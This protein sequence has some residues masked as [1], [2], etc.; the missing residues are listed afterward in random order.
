MNSDDYCCY[1]KTP[2]TQ[3]PHISKLVRD[4]LQGK[5]SKDLYGAEPSLENLIQQAKLKA[6]KFSYRRPLH[7]ALRKQYESCSF[8]LSPYDK[9]QENVDALLDDQT[10]CV[11]TGHQACLGGGPLYSFYKIIST[12]ATCSRLEQQ[13]PSRKYIPVFWMATE[14][15]DWEEANHFYL[16]E[17]KWTYDIQTLGPVG[18]I[19]TQGMD[20]WIDELEKHLPQGEVSKDIIRLFKHAY[21]SHQTWADAT[22]QW[23]H[24]LFGKYGLVVVDADDADLKR[25]FLPV[26]ESDCFDSYSA[27]DVRLNNEKLIARNYPIQVKPVP[28]N[29]FFIGDGDRTYVEKTNAGF[30]VGGKHYSK[31]DFRMYLHQHPEHFS[32]NVVL[33]PLYQEWILPNIA[34]YG[35]PGE[36]AYWFQLSALFKRWEIPFPMLLLRHGFALMDDK[37]KRIYEKLEVELLELPY[38]DW[39]AHWVKEKSTLPLSLTAERANLTKMFNELEVLASSTDKSMI[40]AVRAQRQ[41]QLKGIQNLEKKLMRAE[42]RF[43]TEAMSHIDRLQAALY[44]AGIPQERHDSLWYWW[45]MWGENPIDRILEQA[46]A[47]VPP[48]YF[49]Y[50]AKEV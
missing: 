3:A 27:E 20:K 40:G 2:F 34:Y 14:D 44:P 24:D 9:V 33:R 42:K 21:L 50:F 45:I 36:M 18:R 48:A 1:R 10:V 37:L 23:A 49:V 32:P 12:I 5:L 4:Y 6:E 29:L 26:M 7:A 8:Q 19:S 30:T 31:E 41:K 43:H 16:G 38:K 47:D 25:L 35:G 17:E 22:R 46:K 13:D 15:H 39:R 28:I 11:T